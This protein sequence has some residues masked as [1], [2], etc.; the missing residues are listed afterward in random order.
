MTD[1]TLQKIEP[2]FFVAPLLFFIVLVFIYPV[3]RIF[4]WSFLVSRGGKYFLSLLNYR[5][6][7]QD[8]Q[9][10]AAI[11][12]N[13]TLLLAVSILITLSLFFSI[14]LYQRI[15][16]WKIFRF[17]LFIPV[18]LSVPVV[19]VVFS[20]ILELNGVLNI[21]FHFLRLDFL[22]FDW[23]GRPDI[24]LY[25]VMM[26]IVWKEVGFGIIL[27]LARLASVQE[28]LFEAARIDGAN[29]L[30]LHLYITIPQLWTIIR[31]YTIIT[32]MT[33]LTWVFS[34]IY[35]LTGGGPVNSTITGGLYIY[36]TAFMYHE[37]N[38]ATAGSVIYFCVAVVLI[39]ISRYLM[40][41]G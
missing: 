10:M 25:S 31:F 4:Q 29:W 32:M 15:K 34:Y 16:G 30:Q 22:T 11:K 19:S 1:K 28:E 27:F 9:F 37:I 41:S 24:A 26:V 7:F 23:F 40:K 6:L 33:M 39:F 38:I 3:F 17:C 21:C 5:L 8:N 20:Y 35:T 2:Y 14:I 36:R 13:L 18:I 12:H